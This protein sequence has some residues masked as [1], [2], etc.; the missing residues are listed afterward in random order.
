MLVNKS[1]KQLLKTTQHNITFKFDD[2][3]NDKASL[4]QEQEKKKHV[5]NIDKIVLEIESQNKL[6]KDKMNET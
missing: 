4:E 1:K 6:E 5:V 2:I 3:N